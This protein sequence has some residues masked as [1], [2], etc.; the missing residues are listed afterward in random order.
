M[1]LIKT[2][3]GSEDL[4]SF[5]ANPTISKDIKKKVLNDL[6]SEPLPNTSIVINLLSQNNRVDM[7]LDVCI[8]F[9]QQ[10]NLQ[11]GIVEV[12]VTSA[13]EVS[14][15]ME[16]SIKEYLQS[17]KKGKIKLTKQQDKSLICLLYTSP[18]P[19]DGLLSRMPSS[20]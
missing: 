6:T 13:V 19:R 3:E 9:I 5:I 18:S 12:T 2:L 4:R 16:S 11:R 1:S 17:L 15:D 14:E 10:Y 7:L 20:A 8:G